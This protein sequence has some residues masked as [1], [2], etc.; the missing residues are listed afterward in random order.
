MLEKKRR[1]NENLTALKSQ[2][3]DMSAAFEVLKNT[4]IENKRKMEKK[5]E[6]TYDEIEENKEFTIASMNHV[7]DVVNQF[8]QK[9]QDELQKLGDDLK[10]QMDDEG[11]I[12]RKQWDDYHTR[13]DDC[14]RRINQE[15]DDRIKYHDDHLNPI[16]TQLK[17]IEDGLVKEKKLRITQEKKVIQEI[18]DESNNMQSDIKKEHQMRQ[19]RMQ[20]L[21]DQLTQDTDL[22]N[23]FL[24]NFESNAT[25]SAN[26]F[27]TDLE[28]ELDNRFKH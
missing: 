7:H 26:T 6:D 23:K 2:M 13:M 12:F 20:D 5:F 19:Q 25:K 16:R 21:D 11:E 9:F 18:K 17:G 10:R 22:T 27:L 24:D 28:S 8:Q 1:E 3:K 4:R 14:E 15:R